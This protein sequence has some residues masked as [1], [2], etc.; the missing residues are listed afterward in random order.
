L[1]HWYRRSS[2]GRVHRAGDS[3]EFRRVVFVATA[4]AGALFAASP[5]RAQEAASAAKS[6]D[7]ELRTAGQLVAL[8]ST[9]PTQPLHVSARA[10]CYGFVSG[11]Q[12]YH[13]EVA[14][15]TALGP[16]FCPDGRKTRD[17]LVEVFV[18]SI[19]ANPQRADDRPVDAVFQ[20]FAERWPCPKAK[21]EGDAK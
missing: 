10:F 19:R 15:I 3:R 14:S 7:F 4:V 6:S 21:R 13:D 8:C 12:H 1:A 16:V 20:A 11:G 5:L 2:A 9:S 18:A 17:E